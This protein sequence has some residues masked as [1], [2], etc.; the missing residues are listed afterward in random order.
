MTE[1][2]INGAR[3]YYE[4]F[5]TGAPV[6][7]VHGLGGNGTDTWKKVTAELASELRVIACDLRGSG[8][9]QISPGPYTIEQLTDDLAALVEMLGLERVSVIG[10]SLG[11]GIALLYAA[12]R[13]E[14]VAAIVGLGAV[15]EL[16]EQGRANMAARAETVERDG[17]ADVAVAVA[18]AG[19]APSFREANPDDF[20]EYIALLAA[21]EPAGYAAQCR[22]LSVMTAPYLESVSS[23][24]LLIAGELD[25]SSP[26]AMNH[27][28]AAR[29]Y[30]ARVLE[31][32]DCAHIIPWEKPAELL[33]AVRPYL[34]EHR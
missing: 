8:R 20:Q 31:L 6:V 13:P 2:S 30:R 23:P 1:V 15:A 9:S 19:L 33:D 28:N 25:Q 11:G 27:A 17:M 7:L 26:P 10:H 12:T 5:G 34:K 3:L 22:A 24:V 4:E 21:N 16:P 32:A 14:K 18:T 29:I